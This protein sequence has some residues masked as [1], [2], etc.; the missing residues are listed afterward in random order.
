MTF[1]LKYKN[2]RAIVIENRAIINVIIKKNYIKIANKNL[3]PHPLQI[4][5]DIL[6][7][8][9]TTC[10]ITSSIFNAYFQKL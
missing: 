8:V 7:F 4:P 2:I 9:V 6:A 5:V 1:C 3:Y 10:E